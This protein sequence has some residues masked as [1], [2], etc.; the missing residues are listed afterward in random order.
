[1]MFVKNMIKRHVRLLY[2]GTHL[3]IPPDKQ[4]HIVPHDV[5][6]S[7]IDLEVVNAPKQQL[8]TLC[9][10]LKDRSEM[11]LE[12]IENIVNDV[13]A[14]YFDFIITEAKSKNPLVIPPRL[15]KFIKHFYVS[16]D[17][18][19][20][21]AKLLNFGF[22][23]AQTPLVAGWDADFRFSSK[24][25]ERFFQLIAHHDFEKCGYL[26]IVTT[27]TDRTVRQGVVREA[28]SPYGGLHVHYMKYV[29]ELN[30][31][32]ENF[33]DFGWEEIDFLTRISRHV[34][35]VNWRDYF[36]ESYHEHK[37]QGLIF[38]KSHSDDLRSKNFKRLPKNKSLLTKHYEGNVTK[39][40]QPN[41][42]NTCKLLK[43]NDMKK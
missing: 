36:N 32:D 1:M 13:S 26:S 43:V 28:G 10:P 11:A 5:V 25:P 27:E 16:A 6:V 21:R 4:Y 34:D 23:R 7:S 20:N 41:W 39:L 29:A 22:R 15:R 30:G 17:R 40:D 18:V 2:R 31:Y 9:M 38:H 35:P 12:A 37:E 33:K 42:G 3:V 8:I 24:F 14:K 19:W